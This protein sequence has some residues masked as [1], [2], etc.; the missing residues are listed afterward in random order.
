MATTP[1]YSV[2]VVVGDTT[3]NV[4]GVLT[5]LKLDE[6]SKQFAQ[7]ATIQLVNILHNGKYLTSIFDVID[8]VYVTATYDGVTDEVFRG[9]IWTDDYRSS[10]D[11]YIELKCYDNLIFPQKSEICEYFTAGKTTD[12]IIQTLCDKWGVK[13][14]YQYK[15]ISHPKLP[16]E[17]NLMDVLT[18]D[19]LDEVKKQTGVKYVIRSNKGVVDIKTVGTNSKIYEIR[20]KKNSGRVRHMTTMDE[21][22]TQV[23]ITGKTDDDER[24]PIEA[25]VKGDT[26]RYG[27]IQKRISKSEDTSLEESKQEAQ[28]MLDENGTPK[29]TIEITQSAD[30]PF[31]H[32]GDIVLVSS[33]DIVERYCLVLA[34]THNATR[35]TMDLELEF[36]DMPASDE[37]AS[38]GNTA[39][40]TELKL[41]G[42]PLYKSSDISTKSTT[43][44]GTY[45]L[46]DGIEVNGR[47]RITNTKSRVG[48]KPVGHN[49]TGWIDKENV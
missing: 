47:Y 27:T 44:S 35:K 39:A 26:N 33:G 30:I 3:Y 38:G 1:K 25:T 16:L 15:T 12:A 43:V 7:I 8:E 19:V 18:A 9:Y 49:V 2:K 34:V 37:S 45:Y 29:E 6:H 32:K 14:N 20:S 22:V 31:V 28:E 24:T 13:T 17:G 21:V 23:I 36:F 42:V 10:D 41:S 46:Y 11:K 4:D 48:A 40:G 5:D